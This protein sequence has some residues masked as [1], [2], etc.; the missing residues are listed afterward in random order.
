MGGGT[1]RDELPGRVVADGAVAVG[2]GAVDRPGTTERDVAGR[3]LGVVPNGEGAGMR[4]STGAVALAE[5]AV[6]GLEAAEPF[7][8][9][10]P[11]RDV[12]GRSIESISTWRRSLARFVGSG[13]FK[14]LENASSR[15]R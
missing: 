11:A 9:E 14:A 3:R 4:R 8:A 1:G 15:C 7:K 2:E 10:F 6:E 13:S 5:G 12:P